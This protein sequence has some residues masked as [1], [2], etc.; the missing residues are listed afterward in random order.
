MNY[1]WIA[2]V[3]GAAVAT[4]ACSSNDAA[5]AT[6]ADVDA[7]SVGDT[8]ECAGDA[9]PY[10]VDVYEANLHKVGTNGVLTFNLVSSS[11]APP[12]QGE[13]TFVVQV[14]HADGSPFTGT[15][16]IPYEGM[17]M[18]LHGHGAPSAPLIA[19]DPAQNAFV[20]SDMD[21]FMLGLWRVQLQA[22]EADG[23]GEAGNDAETDATTNATPTDSATFYFCL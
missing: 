11:P 19:F 3:F 15:L 17:W 14:T 5:T 20:L 18:P 23:S 12:E 2:T 10:P 8:V 1:R 9:S 13:D 6:D 7:G 16:V 22:F 4:A 21:F